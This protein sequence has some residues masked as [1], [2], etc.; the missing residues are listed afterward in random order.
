MN[1]SDIVEKIKKL[2]EIN[3]SNG[4]T[5]AEE[6]AAMERANVLMTKYQIEE[7]QLH[8]AAKTRNIH[9]SDI[10]E[11]KTFTFSQFLCAVADFFGVLSLSSTNT[12]AF[13]G[14]PD[15]VNLA[16]DMVKRG[17]FS[18]SLSFTDYLCSDEYRKN[19]RGTSRTEV[20]TSFHDGFYTKIAAKLEQLVDDRK[21]ATAEATGRDLVVL[22][23]QNLENSFENDF[24]LKLKA[25]RACRQRSVDY[26]AFQAGVK[27]GDEFKI[28]DEV[29]Q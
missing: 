27:K 28:L 19:R 21:Q 25:G 9:L 20:K 5:E 12:Y 8:T 4:A 16:K 17:T 3:R 10:L 18:L 11:D 22:N 29:T 6:M 7:F 1:K 26:A 2:L 15:N 13:Y 23:E 14:A 24:G